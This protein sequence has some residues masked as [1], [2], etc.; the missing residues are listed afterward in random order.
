MDTSQTTQ[1]RSRDCSGSAT[2]G[3]PLWDCHLGTAG[4]RLPWCW[5]RDLT[6]NHGTQPNPNNSHFSGQSTAETLQPLQDGR[7]GWPSE[8]TRAGSL[9]PATP[10]EEEGGFAS[11]RCCGNGCQGLLGA[12]VCS[13]FCGVPGVLTGPPEE[14]DPAPST[15]T[16]GGRRSRRPDPLPGLESGITRGK[17]RRDGL[18]GLQREQAQLKHPQGPQN[19]T[20]PTYAWGPPPPTT[21]PPFLWVPRKPAAPGAP[22]HPGARGGPGCTHL[23]TSLQRG[24]KGCC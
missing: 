18:S 22:W 2:R 20:N 19:Q 12:L 5:P 11:A 24:G 16:A 10:Q 15:G 1:H 13:T 17:W 3:Q 8:P 7:A 6:A 4:G 14:G 9:L 21:C 23:R